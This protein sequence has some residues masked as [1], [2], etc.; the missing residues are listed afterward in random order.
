V[1]AEAWLTKRELAGPREDHRRAR[2]AG[3]VATAKRTIRL[4][5]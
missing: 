4:A 1:N 5:K 2:K 3:K